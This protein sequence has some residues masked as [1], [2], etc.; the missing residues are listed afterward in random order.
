MYAGAAKALPQVVK[1]RATSLDTALA[2]SAARNALKQAARLGVF[3][4]YRTYTAEQV[5]AKYAADATV[6]TAAA[7]RTNP[8]VNAAGAS[9]AIGAGVGRATCGCP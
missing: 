9:L 3:P 8:L 5:L 6:I 7:T 2:V 1:Q 4:N